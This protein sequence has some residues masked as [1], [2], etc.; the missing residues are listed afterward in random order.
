MTEERSRAIV[1]ALEVIQE[2]IA[3]PGGLAMAREE[4]LRMMTRRCHVRRIHRSSR[5]Q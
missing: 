5:A 2:V 4:A 3:E 1:A